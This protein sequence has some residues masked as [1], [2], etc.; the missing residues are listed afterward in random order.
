MKILPINKGFLLVGVTVIFVII[1]ITYFP[2]EHSNYN[3]LP[4]SSFDMF[5][6][7][8]FEFITLPL[9]YALDN[10]SL[11][12]QNIILYLLMFLGNIF[13]YGLVLERILSFIIHKIKNK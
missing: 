5:L 8:L 4:N 2:W 6:I 7:K 9:N 12:K 1:L 3:G 11:V 13:I 10:W